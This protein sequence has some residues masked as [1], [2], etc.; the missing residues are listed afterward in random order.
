VSTLTE[1]QF[2]FY[3]TRSGNISFSK[4]DTVL[5]WMIVAWLTNIDRLLYLPLNIANIAF[6]QALSVNLLMLHGKNMIPAQDSRAQT[7]RRRKLHNV[8]Q[9]TGFVARETFAPPLQST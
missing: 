4:T 8:D 7:Q 9:K 6:L 2:F 1:K 5:D 3:S